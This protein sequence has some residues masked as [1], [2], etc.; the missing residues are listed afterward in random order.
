MALVCTAAQNVEGAVGDPVLGMEA[1]RQ[2]LLAIGQDPAREGLVDTPRRVIKSLL[3]M[4]SG[5]H[6]DPAAILAT[7]FDESCDEMVLLRSITFQSMCEHHM[8]PFVGVAHVAYLPGKRVVGLSKL[9]RLVQ[10][11]ARRLQVQERMTREIADAMM[12]HLEAAGAAVVV[13]ARH[14]CMTNRG[15]R[16]PGAEMITSCVLGKFREDRAVR[17]EFLALIGLPA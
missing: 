6:D 1:V 7:T 8:L 12:Q 2:L 16:Q 3:E 4:T 11:F 17:E 5:Y 15:I 14:E 9:A 10:C 13:K